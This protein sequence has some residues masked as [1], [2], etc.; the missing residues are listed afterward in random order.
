MIKLK[1]VLNGRLE[2]EVS[3]F[4]ATLENE[5][6]S[7]YEVKS[8]TVEF[9]HSDGGLLEHKFFAPVT[10]SSCEFEESGLAY[11]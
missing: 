4:I 10:D 11:E 5:F 1:S 3:D 2:N 7:I 6:E 8:V 9:I